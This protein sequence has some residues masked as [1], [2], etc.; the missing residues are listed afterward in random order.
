MIHPGMTNAYLASDLKGGHFG[1]EAG[2]DEVA[3]RFVVFRA[4]RHRVL[5]RRFRDIL[6]IFRILQHHE[7]YTE[8]AI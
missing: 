2:L 8:I 3:Y 1:M 7:L 6:G 5:I 4:G